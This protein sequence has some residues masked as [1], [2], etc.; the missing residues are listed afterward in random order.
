MITSNRYYADPTCEACEGAGMIYV[1]ETNAYTPCDCHK[2]TKI[3]KMT[4]FSGV[5]GRY[6][7]CTVAGYK[8]VTAGEL[9]AWNAVKSWVESYKARQGKGRAADGAMK[10]LLLLGPVGTGKTHLLSAICLA[11]IKIHGVQPVYRTTNDYL[12]R[13]KDRFDNP[14]AADEFDLCASECEVLA[15][16]DLGLERPTDWSV[17]E[18]CDLVDTRYREDLTLIAASNLTLPAMENVYGGR[19]T[20][21][22]CQMCD[23]LTC[24]GESRRRKEMK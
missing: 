20:D 13:M 23:F 24:D 11:L 21:R 1:E 19:L 8:P 18:L 14:E 10:G 3:R 16:D 5:P 15:L 2:R 6:Y 12:R 17:N 22:L 7:G 4:E 9:A